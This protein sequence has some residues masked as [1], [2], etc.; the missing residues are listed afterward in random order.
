MTQVSLSVAA[1]AALTSLAEATARGKGTLGHGSGP[2]S[3]GMGLGNGSTSLVLGHGAT[4]SAGSELE[5][6]HPPCKGGPKDLSGMGME[7]GKGD[8]IT[9]VREGALPPATAQQAI[10]YAAGEPDSTDQGSSE[11]HMLST[12]SISA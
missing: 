12:P 4:L 2:L 1:A 6:D 9:M 11:A 3:S 8:G 10:L 5:C 7:L